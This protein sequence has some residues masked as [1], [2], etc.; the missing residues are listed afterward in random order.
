MTA[1]EIPSSSGTLTPS[2]VLGGPTVTSVAAT[3]TAVIVIVDVVA[4]AVVVALV[5]VKRVTTGVLIDTT[6]AMNWR[7]VASLS[8]CVASKAWRSVGLVAWMAAAIAGPLLML[9]MA[10]MV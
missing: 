6:R 10:E 2:D 9:L 8:M 7:T 5:S 4:V 1:T 3:V